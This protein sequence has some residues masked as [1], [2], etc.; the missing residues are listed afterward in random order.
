MTDLFHDWRFW[1]LVIPAFLG[2]IGWFVSHLVSSSKWRGRVDTKLEGI[3]ALN[4]TVSEI[5][6]DFE[7]ALRDIF[8]RLP[9]PQT[10]ISQSPV[11]L[12]DFGR[13][14]SAELDMSS[15]LD[16]HQSNVVGITK[17]KEEFEIFE[18][19][20]AYVRDLEESDDIFKR[21]ISSAAYNF[22]TEPDQIRKIY[23]IELRDCILGARL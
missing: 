1:G 3:D 17:G 21:M 8:L 13:K 19:C 2:V 22:G 20:V 11:Q 15:W 12:T 16:T 9:P 7:T 23:Q 14:I 5:K 4:K 18:E 6:R 10:A